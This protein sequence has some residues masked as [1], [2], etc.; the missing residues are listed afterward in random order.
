MLNIIDY[1]LT[2]NIKLFMN[3]KKNP[4]VHFVNALNAISLSNSGY[5]SLPGVQ[6]KHILVV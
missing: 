5:I 2:I 6:M 3:N 1:F 4:M